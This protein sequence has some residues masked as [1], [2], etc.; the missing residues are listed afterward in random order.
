MNQATTILTRADPAA[1]RF[2]LRIGHNGSNT[3]RLAHSG[4][5]FFCFFALRGISRILMRSSI[6]GSTTNA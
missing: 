1:L 6:A 3:G 2:S 5:K 4:N